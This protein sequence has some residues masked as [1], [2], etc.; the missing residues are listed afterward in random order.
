MLH[1]VGLAVVVAVAAVVHQDPYAVV[2]LIE[3]TAATVSLWY[4]HKLLEVLFFA[5]LDV[6][7]RG[8]HLVVAE[9]QQAVTVE[10][11]VEHRLSSGFP[12][13]LDFSGEGDPVDGTLFSG[14]IE[15]IGV[16]A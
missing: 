10:E 15:G 14:G 2:H 12:N 6:Q 13:L 8:A 7:I 11:H 3:L 5:S 16:D 9:P 4:G 1:A